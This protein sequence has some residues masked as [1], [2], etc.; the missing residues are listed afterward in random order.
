MYTILLVSDQYAT[1]AVIKNKL[2]QVDPEIYLVCAGNTESAHAYC[3]K[4]DI[5]MFLFD[6]SRLDSPIMNFATDIRSTDRY[7]FTPIIFLLPD[8]ETFP[9]HLAGFHLYDYICRPLFDDALLYLSQSIVYHSMQWKALENSEG[10]FLCLPISGQNRNISISNIMFIESSDHMCLVHTYQGVHPVRFP[11]Y[12]IEEMAE[13]TP[14]MRTHNSYIVNVN[15]IENIDK[16]AAT[17]TIYFEN[18]SDTALVGRSYKKQINAWLKNRNSQY[19]D[20]V[21]GAASNANNTFFLF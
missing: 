5:R 11:L 8:D 16:D 17:W 13:G 21:N 6:L 3:L 7:R 15:H 1:Y 4:H 20:Y 12:K 14:L 10:Q 19:V 2:K 9:C 18:A